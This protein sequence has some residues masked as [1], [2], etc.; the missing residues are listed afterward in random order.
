MVV[1]RPMSSGLRYDLVVDNGDGSF[2][3]IQCKT[4]MLKDG[5]IFF[6]TYNADARRPHGVRYFGQVEAFGV[7]C[8][9]TGDAFLVPATAL[10]TTGTAR[11]RVSAARNGQL[12][13]ILLA[14]RFRI[15]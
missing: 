13:R 9:Q 12:K 14:D 2:M 1:L 11:L 4:G 6:R 8:P 3:R 15:Q 7:F 5:A 10:E